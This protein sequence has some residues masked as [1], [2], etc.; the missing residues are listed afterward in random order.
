MERIAKALKREYPD[1]SFRHRWKIS[2]K[3]IHERLSAIDPS[4]GQ[5]LFVKNVELDGTPQILQAASFYFQSEP[6]TAEAIYW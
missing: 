6:W 3:E 5:V 1:L 2:K 4:L